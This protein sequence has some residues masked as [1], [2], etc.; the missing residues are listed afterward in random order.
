MDSCLDH[1]P[2]WHELITAVAH[3]LRGAAGAMAHQVELLSRSELDSALAQ[4][5]LA[6][7]ELNT[8]ALSRFADTLTDLASV[9]SPSSPPRSSTFELGPVVRSVAAGTVAVAVERIGEPGW[10][11]V[12]VNGDVAVL[13]RV[14]TVL[15]ERLGEAGPASIGIVDGAAGTEIV[16]GS[17]GLTTAADSPPV[18]ISADHG[19]DVV[20]AATLALLHRWPVLTSTT[21]GGT[22]R[23][24][25]RLRPR[26]GAEQAGPAIDQGGAAGS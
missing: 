12:V 19:L 26:G 6:M 15:L 5:S 23:Y 2:D 20:A 8:N 22:Y 24:H 14:L 10:P 21:A 17:G 25:V 11:R 4:Q 18:A 1:E 16:I 3:D 13:R 9:R 7:L